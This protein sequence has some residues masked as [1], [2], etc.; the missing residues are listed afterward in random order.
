MTKNQII[1][2]IIP[3]SVD[4][5]PQGFSTDDL[6]ND[7]FAE[8]AN[9]FFDHIIEISKANIEGIDGY[10]EFNE[11]GQLPFT[12]CREFLVG[13]FSDSSEGYWHKWKEMFQTTCLDETFFNTYFEKMVNLIP[14]VEGRRSLVNNNT[15]FCY[16]VTDGHSKIGFPDWS[17]SGIADPLLDIALMDLNKPYLLIPEKFYHYCKERNI[18]VENFK[19]RFL[20][21]AYYKGID[22]LRW[23]A[24]IDDDVSCRSIMAS[25]SGLEQRMM[26]LK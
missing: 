7:K 23:H 4:I 2:N 14:S 24:S 25:L 26:T 15:F 16:M 3:S 19:E 17:R 20:C 22:T 12:T 6:S 1:R 10:G 9:F 21:M 5:T 11:D 13:T 8:M 18:P